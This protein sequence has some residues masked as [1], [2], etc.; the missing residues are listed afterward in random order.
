MDTPE[1]FDAA[2]KRLSVALEKLEAATERRVK[3]EALRANLEEE[4]AVMQD[5]RSRLA[6]ELDGAL[7]RSSSLEATSD[8]V[9]RRLN[10]A[11]AAVKAVL[12]GL[13]TG[14]LGRCC[15]AA[16]Y[17]ALIWGA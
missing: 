12:G 4:L 13:R 15:A 1:R 7:A 11:S 6:V 16:F 9:A 10:E 17:F 8:E 2:L 5:D 3:A 14:E